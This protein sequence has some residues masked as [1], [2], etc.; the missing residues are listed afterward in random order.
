MYTDIKDFSR[1]MEE[2]ELG[3]LRLLDYHNDIIKAQ[4]KEHRGTL[5]KTIGDAVLAHFPTAMDAV[6]A[7]LGVQ[8]E[9][10]KYNLSHR[11]K[12]LLVRIGV[13]LGDIYFTENDA[14]GEGIN[15]AARLQSISRPG[16]ICL[17]Q[18]VFNQVDGKLGVSSRDLG[19]VE[20]KNIT[21]VI[22]AHELMIPS[23]PGTDEKEEKASGE[24]AAAAGAAASGAS[25]SSRAEEALHERLKGSWEAWDRAIGSE[26]TGRQGRPSWDQSPR[27]RSHGRS[28]REDREEIKHF[29]ISQAEKV[30]SFFRGDKHPSYDG[31]RDPYEAYRNWRRRFDA[32]CEKMDQSFRGNLISYLSVNGFLLLINMLT[33]PVFPWFLFP[34]GGWGIGVASHWAGWRSLKK[35]Q[36][37]LNKLPELD[38]EQLA[39]F[40]KIQSNERNFFTHVVSSGAVSLFLLMINLITAPGFLWAL[41]PAGAMAIGVLGSWGSYKSRRKKF[42]SRFKELLGRSAPRGAG[43]SGSPV[44]GTSEGS[45]GESPRLREVKNLKLS[46]ENQMAGFDTNPL[47][48]DAKQILED[49]VNQIVQLDQKNRE[50][51]SLLVSMPLDGMEEQ[52]T[53]LRE[54]M[55]GTESSALQEEY[56]QS[57]QGIERQRK[58][59]S[60]LREQKEILELR[61]NTA[62]S[63]MKQMNIDL[64]RMKNLSEGEDETTA[65][66]EGLRRRTRELS[67]YIE[68]FNDS[69]DDLEI[70]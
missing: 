22:N 35:T 18:E 42:L 5:I 23:P 68:D 63:N 41:I 56:Q 11:E 3:T 25:S 61:M 58:S 30:G 50:M 13:H 16:R 34:A 7:S 2:D 60:A 21:R 64:A 44:W 55:A 36:K 33:A 52:V 39:L 47:G 12:P 8:L 38:E 54:K 28:A 53:A 9:F 31:P 57:I 14:F 20:L 37:A 26:G 49:Y 10:S 43:D 15:I 29:V 40:K 4:I 24:A 32:N 59:I 66:A 19:R 1:M 27:G 17:S 6:Q 70:D 67:Q 65:R 48:D 69:Y 62:V 45:E 46:I 51:E